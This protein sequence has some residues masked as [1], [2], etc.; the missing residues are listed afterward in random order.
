MHNPM[1]Q[2]VT[3]QTGHLRV[4]LVDESAGISGAGYRLEGSSVLG[5]STGSFPRDLA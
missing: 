5:S 1:R 2:R 4:V 3:P